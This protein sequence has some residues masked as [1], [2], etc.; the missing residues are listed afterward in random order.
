M[1]E[2]RQ[3]TEADLKI[4][5]LAKIVRTEDSISHTH[6]VVFGR[7]LTTAERRLF[8]E[9]LTGFYYTVHFS[10]QFDADF[11]AEPFVEFDS[12]QQAKYTLYQKSLSGSAWKTLLFAILANFSYEVAPIARHDESKAF[13]PQP[14]AI[15]AN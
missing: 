15:A 11:L 13:A 10:G 8:V 12:P 14:M 7:P 1:A 4:G 5:K 3:Y 2:K 6:T 9:V